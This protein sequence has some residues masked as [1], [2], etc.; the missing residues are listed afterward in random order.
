M[1]PELQR[2]ARHLPKRLV[3]LLREIGGQADIDDRNGLR[4]P[5]I[6]R[7]RDAV[8]D[9]NIVGIGI[10]EKIVA[11]TPS[12]A[13]GITFYV[14]E[15]RASPV[16]AMR[17]LLP[18]L[19][20]DPQGRAIY[21]DVVEIGVAA[22]QVQAASRPIKSGFS[23]AHDRGGAGTVGA[24]VYKGGK[25]HILSAQHVLADFDRGAAGDAICYPARSDND[26][27]ANRVAQLLPFTSIDRSP[28]FP[29]RVDAALA[30]LD[31]AAIALIDPALPGASEPLRIGDAVRDMD[32]ILS[33]RTSPHARA[34]VVTPLTLARTRQQPDGIAGF[35]DQILCGPLS[36]PGD[37]G[38]LVF[39][40]DSG[41]VI[42]MIIGGS[43]GSASYVT[44]IRAVL[45]AVGARFEP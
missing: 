37:S 42:G 25:P 3:K 22:A 28:G 38:A 8:L 34:K 31:P 26:G 23:V 21:T 19:L 9:E 16:L 27:N 39:A 14:A 17:A 20:S 12:G 30:R 44:P 35:T 6:E 36:E 4:T 2:P 1:N 7:L 45:S 18:T 24:I 10:A 41:A 40:A 5:M 43:P 13:L 29:N 15:K 11:G 32:V 33:G